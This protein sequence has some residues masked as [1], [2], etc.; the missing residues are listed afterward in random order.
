MSEIRFYHL[1]KSS[2]EQTL[3][4]LISKAYGTG[5]KMV[6]R[7]QNASQREDIN[8]LLWTYRADSFLPHGSEADEFA[9]LQP[10]WVTDK[11]ENP[12]AADILIL[13]HGCA[14]SNDNAFDLVCDVF[15]GNDAESLNAA[16]ARWKSLKDPDVKLTYWQQTEQGAWEQK[17]ES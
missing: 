15:D 9:D 17:A 3:P 5:R 16:R 14:V 12:N 13:T 11:D 7:T 8:T 10:I 6:I 2:L 1:Q 4:A